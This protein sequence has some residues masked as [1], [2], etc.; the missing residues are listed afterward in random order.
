MTAVNAEERL[1]GASTI[2]P[3]V[4]AQNK[5]LETGSTS[6]DLEESSPRDPNIVDWDG[7]ND[8]A[9]PQNWSKKKK[10]I[11][12]SLVSSVT[13]VTPLASSIFAPGIEQVMAD[14]HSTN[15]Q[16]ASFIVS[17]YLLGYCFGPLV[18]APL[19]EMYGRLHIYNI[20][21][22]LF[23]IFNIGCAKAP[24]L[25]GLIALRFLA[26]LAGCC[27]LA[28]GA[29]SLADMISQEKRGLAMA[30]WILGPITGPIIGPIAGG[31][32]TQAKSWRWSFW[33]VAIVSGAITILNFIFMRETYAYTIL[34]KK[35]KRLQKETGNM[36]LRSVAD[37]GRSPGALFRH[38]IVRPTKMLFFSPIVFLLSLYMAIVYGY[39]YL[40]F[41]AMPILFQQEYG[42]STGSV[43]LAYIGIGAGSVVGLFIAG[44]ISDPLVRHLTKKNGGEPMPE[45]RLPIMVIASVFVPAGLFLYGWTA[46]KGDHWILPILGTSFLGFGMMCAMMGSSVY[47]VDAYAEFAASAMSASTV[48]RSLLGALLPLAGRKMYD[49]LGY[50]WGTS[51]LAFIAV[52]MIPMP[53]VF[54][55]YGERIR[56]RNLFGVEF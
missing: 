4:D 32:L 46:E 13:F 51:L 11:T 21:N 2:A 25:G 10:V 3:T 16:L 19:S 29:G 24:N 22:V 41:T 5:D 8:P 55:K 23:V 14:F 39:L 1:D 33:V 43:G 56:K 31:Y 30:S 28:L 12:V 15:Q 35:T 20:C 40:I 53:F 48:L 54:L 17:V 18:L 49:Q 37:T 27:P 50:G 36:K 38:A 26:G 9:N 42:F 7:P 47:L 52:A 6:V 44:G 34:Q 45:Y